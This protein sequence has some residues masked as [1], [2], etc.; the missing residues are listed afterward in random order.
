MLVYSGSLRLAL[1]TMDPACEPEA[2]RLGPQVGLG[3]KFAE[4][5]A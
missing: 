4:F 5:G 1:L 2:R 3:D